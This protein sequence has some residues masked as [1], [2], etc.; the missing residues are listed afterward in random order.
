[1]E[2][3]HRGGAGIGERQFNRSQSRTRAQDKKK[4]KELERDVQ[5]KDRALAE[6]TALLVLK[7]KQTWSGAAGRTSEH[8]RSAKLHRDGPASQSRWCKG[9]ASCEVLE[10]SLR[11][12]E[13]WEK[14]PQKGD[15]KRGPVTAC[16]HALSAQE[17]QAIVKESSSAQYRDI[18]PW[19][20]VAR[21]A[22]GGRYL[23]S[24]SSFYRV[25]K[26]NDLL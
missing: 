9:Q 7:K 2:E 11:T 13:R 8:R 22:D 14:A 6:T 16:A 26:Q 15:Q 3:E 23:G 17:K 5:R 10:V 19:Q 25:L 1:M 20:M 18:S 4:I 21:L 12:V 24:E